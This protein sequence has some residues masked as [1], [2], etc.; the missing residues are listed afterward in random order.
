MDRPISF[1]EVRTDGGAQG[2]GK[3]S[4][5]IA[6][7]P[8]WKLSSVTMAAIAPPLAELPQSVAPATPFSKRGSKAQAAFAAV[9]GPVKVVELPPPSGVKARIGATGVV[10][11]F[12][13]TIVL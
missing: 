2:L 5:V 9:M 1:S 6:P 3:P 13:T 11:R 4:Y 12:W 8:P 7:S 10:P